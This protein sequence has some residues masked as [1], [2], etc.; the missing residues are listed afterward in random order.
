MRG[1]SDNLKRIRC[2]IKRF[3][4]FRYI[5]QYQT[6]L[7]TPIAAADRKDLEV[8]RNA[9]RTAIGDRPDWDDYENYP[10]DEAFVRYVQRSSP[11]LV[12]SASS[13]RDAD[14]RDLV[15]TY[16]R[17]VRGLGG[18]T[19]GGHGSSVGHGSVHGGSSR[20]MTGDF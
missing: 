10:P 12:D 18:G 17:W 11:A 8:Y 14:G 13:R 7:E 16:E 6:L 9:V 4:S 19:G 3:T 1:K 20:R 2:L 5:N 15:A